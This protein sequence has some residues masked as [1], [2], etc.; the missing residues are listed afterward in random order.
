MLN[1]TQLQVITNGKIISSHDDLA[2]EHFLLDSR[3]ITSPSSSVFVAIKGQRHD[4]HKFLNDLYNKG[5]RQ[6]IVETSNASYN[7]PE[8][9]ILEVS[10][11]VEA[12]QNIAAWHRSQFNIPVIGI[13]GSNGK[14]IIKEWLSQ[15]LCKDYNI[16]RSPKSYNSQVGVPLSVWQMNDQH[17]LGIFEAGISLPNEMQNLK[18]VIQPTIGIFT[19]IGTAHDEGFQ[20]KEQ[21]IQEKLKLFYD[22]E[23]LVYCKDHTLIDEQV[24]NLLPNKK[25]FTWSYTNTADVQVKE[26][27]KANSKSKIHIQYQGQAYSYNIPFYDDASIENIIHCITTL[28]LFNV[29]SAEIDNRIQ[30]LHNVAMRLE[31]KE[32]INGC[33]IIDDTYNNDL[34][35]LTIAINF[36]DQQKRKED[37]TIILSDV[38]ESGLEEKKLYKE[39]ASLINGKNIQK[40]IGIGETISRNN[41]F[42]PAESKFYQTTEEFLN[43]F[44][45]ED[46]YDEIILIKGARKFEFEKIVSQLQQ[47][48]HGTILEVNLDALSNNLNFYKSKL[49]PQT[50][51]MVM[52]KAFAYGSGSFEVAN[53]LQFHRV[54]YLAVAYADEGVALRENG[55]SL[56]I[57]VMNPVYQT[58]DKLFQYNLE[59]EIYSLKVLQEYLSFLQSHEISSKIHIKLDTGMRRLGFEE[60]DIKE[61]I[62]TL[63]SSSLVQVASVFTH[64][65]GA[66]EEAHN[67]FSK[68]QIQKLL[69]LSSMLE[70]KLGYKIMKHALNSAGITRFPEAQMDMVRLG[71]GLYG[72]ECNN[73]YQKELQTVGTLKTIIS[74]TKSIKAGETVGYGRKGKADKDLTIATIAIGYADG[75]NRRFSNG[76]GK[77]LVN[78]KLCPVIG[79]VCMDMTMV[80]VTGVGAEEGQEVIVFGR[81]LSINQVAESIGTIP[82]EILTNVSERVKRVFYSE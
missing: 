21:K 18:K 66:D 43:E 58:F 75:Y 52:V 61:L 16:V 6:F 71:I 23:T 22:V 25:T 63:K 24:K 56:P 37:K 62:Q 39:I 5:V 47:K 74:Q 60:K 2:V 19:N 65:A 80:D 8:A 72:I 33:Y 57:M 3:K 31:L 73:F 78:G 48:V 51:V 13:T 68:N 28:I 36:L 49:K 69:K 67:E 14:T 53:L 10:S 46:F 9:N 41:K 76:V 50:K 77:V 11:S 17:T 40:V 45:Q 79:N 27:T 1:F 35:G 82:Y 44:I 12:L 38:L 20:S 30:S 59:P 81:E 4:G 15:L 7:L 55:I 26:I 70:E 42:F 32:G 64:L 34:A 29:E 54:D